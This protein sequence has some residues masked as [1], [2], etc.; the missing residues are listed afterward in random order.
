MLKKDERVPQISGQFKEKKNH[1][2]VYRVSWKYEKIQ[3]KKELQKRLEVTQ[4][5]SIR[6]SLVFFIAQQNRNNNNKGE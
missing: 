2:S 6:F 4:L 5:H 3:K 1:F